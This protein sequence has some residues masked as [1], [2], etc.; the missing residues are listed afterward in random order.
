MKSEKTRIYGLD[1]VRAIAIAMVIFSH[2][3][4]IFQGYN[5]IMTQGMQIVG[6]QG[7]EI[8]FVL[9]GFLIG[10]ILLR[11]LKNGNFTKK[12]M[13]HFWLRRWFRT[14][15]LYFLMLI[16]NITV[17]LIIGFNLPQD[18][19]KY[20]FFWQNFIEY[21]IP[22]FPESWSLSVEEYAYILAPICIY[23]FSRPFKKKDVVFLYVSIFLVLV[24]FITK[25][26]YYFST[27]NEP[28]SWEV[29]NSRLKAIVVYRLDAIFY[30]FILAYV[31]NRNQTKFKQIKD[32][33][34]VVGI[35][36]WFLFIILMP[37]LGVTIQKFPFYWNVL[38][39]PLNSIGI[40]LIFPYFYF[41]KKPH[42]RVAKLIESISLYSYAVYLLHYTFILY[43]IRLCFDFNT[44]SFL[45][46]IICAILYV[47]GTYILSKL[48]YIYFEKPTTDLRDS[49]LIKRYF[50]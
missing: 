37:L 19:W 8:F 31:F 45:E 32:S 7:V 1:L 44:F 41:L 4:Y 39:L 13:L 50:N 9:S 10:E 12:V 33:L 22:F 20:F 3:L 49:K 40:C 47:L 35:S 6:V 38:Y 2:T 14:L 24:F 21:H 42:K 36:F 28:Q 43:V 27:L 15:P 46:R 16:V 5:N 30:G 29:W 17:A 11:L 34:F 25:M 18:I 48:V 23:I 26:G